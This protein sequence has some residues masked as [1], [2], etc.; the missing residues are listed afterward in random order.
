M[1]Q[2]P[3]P[4]AL[5]ALR[6]PTYYLFTLPL[7]LGGGVRQYHP[8]SLMRNLRL[9]K[10]GSCPGP[11]YLTWRF[12]F[13]KV[14]PGE[15]PQSR[16]WQPTLVFWPGKSHGQRSLESYRP[17][18]L[19]ESHMTEW[20]SKNTRPGT[21]CP[22]AGNVPFSPHTTLANTGLLSFKITSYKCDVER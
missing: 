21:F 1:K 22:V 7:S 11:T 19:T 2:L 6:L 16:K 3:N 18:N 13:R 4:T 5:Q 20:L 8:I 14:K 15:I 9:R 17:W 12:F 10:H